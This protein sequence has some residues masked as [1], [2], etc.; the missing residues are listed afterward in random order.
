MK[1]ENEKTKEQR[2]AEFIAKV[3][4]IQLGIT[5]KTG[6]PKAVPVKDYQHAHAPTCC[7]GEKYAATN[8]YEI[9]G[10]GEL[11]RYVHPK[12]DREE[13]AFPA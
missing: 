11:V 2:D 10:L 3:A 1:S 9:E 13:S 6:P 4:T 12:R 5:K 7:C 8:C